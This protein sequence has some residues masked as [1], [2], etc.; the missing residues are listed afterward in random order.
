MPLIL[1]MHV[2]L[3]ATIMPLL[4]RLLKLPALL[5]LLTPGRRLYGGID[6]LRV[7]A[8]VKRRLER[9]RNMRRRACLREGLMLFHF[10]RLAGYDAAL[11]FSVYPPHDDVRMHAHCWVSL[12]GRC[13]STPAAAGGVL[14]FTYVNAGDAGKLGRIENLAA[15]EMSDV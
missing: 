10:L 9:P 12:D 11:H 5:R 7:I 1:R 8:A 4:V 14:V 2:R 3:L 6:S 13:V 15:K